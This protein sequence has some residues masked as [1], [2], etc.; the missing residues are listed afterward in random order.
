M[1]NKYGA[2][3]TEVDGYKFAS[4]AEARRYEELRLQALAGE[5][6]DLDVHP[7]FALYAAVLGIG[8]DADAP[9]PHLRADVPCDRAERVGFYTADFAYL[10]NG[11]LWVEDVKGK[12]APLTEAFKL[13]KRLVEATYGFTVEVVRM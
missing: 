5:I 10:A 9:T 11:R 7:R 6:T 3:P 8:W 4:G 1:S 13:R 2:R 12:T